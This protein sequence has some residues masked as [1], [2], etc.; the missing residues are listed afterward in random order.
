MQFLKA[1]VTALVTSVVA[2]IVLLYALSSM[3]V[4]PA[5]PLH[6]LSIGPVVG[7]TTFGVIGATVVYALMRSFMYNPNSAFIWVSAV[8]LVVSFVPDYL[9]IGQTTGPF[10]G[11]SWPSALV[12]M[13]MHVVSA[14]LI[15]WSLV[16]IW[17]PKAM[18]PAK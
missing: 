1:F 11:G 5:M 12:L 7:L 13:L 15:V 8:V 4:D 10:A 2:N 14:V 3:V 16:K 9:I 6:A 17:G 18:H